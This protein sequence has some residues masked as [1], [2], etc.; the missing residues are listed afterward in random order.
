MLALP[1]T[2]A[3]ISGENQKNP[4]LE[5]NKQRAQTA[6]DTIKTFETLDLSR[7]PDGPYT[8]TSL[9]YVGDLTVTV[10]VKSGRITSVRVTKH[11]DK[12]YYTA[13]TDTPNRIIEKQGL[14]GIDATTGA[15]I[16]SQAII[17]A[18]AKALASWEN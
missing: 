2:Y 12:Q 7:I 8:G 14:K 1:T 10:T 18:T 3:R 6:I 11:K 17:D 15:T 5:R 16:T 4:I 9:A 13:L